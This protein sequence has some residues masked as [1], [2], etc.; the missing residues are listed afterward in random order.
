MKL[1][2]FDGLGDWQIVRIEDLWGNFLSECPPGK[3][4]RRPK[5]N[6]QMYIKAKICEER[7][8]LEIT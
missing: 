2:E 6:F 7:S 1:G 8:W 4:K 3:L 5:D